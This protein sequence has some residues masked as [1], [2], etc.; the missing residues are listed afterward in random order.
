MSNTLIANTN[1]FSLLLGIMIGIALCEFLRNSKSKSKKPRK[2]RV[3]A[4]TSGHTMPDEWDVDGE[5]TEEEEED[6]YIINQQAAK[7]DDETLYQEYPVTDVKMVLVVN[8]G[9][10]MGKGKIGA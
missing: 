3:V 1:I 9:L 2:A 10:K 7:I 6:G 5:D 4:G 8:N